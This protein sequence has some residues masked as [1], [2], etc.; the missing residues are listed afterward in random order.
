MSARTHFT[1][2]GSSGRLIFDELMRICEDIT[3]IPFGF[4]H[5]FIGT[6]N[7]PIR[8]YA[9]SKRKPRQNTT[10]YPN[11]YIKPGD[12]TAESWEDIVVHDLKKNLL[13]V[14][15]DADLVARISAYPDKLAGEFAYVEEQQRLHANDVPVIYNKYID[16]CLYEIKVTIDK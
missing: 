10:K 7:P 12:I 13:G 14:I 15:K 6:N 11:L 3:G 1:Y 16:K 8:I 9:S 5:K 2:E 4:T